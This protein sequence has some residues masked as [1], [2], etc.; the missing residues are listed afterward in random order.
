MTSPNDKAVFGLQSDFYEHLK[1]KLE[2]IERFYDTVVFSF[3]ERKRLIDGNL[4]PYVD[5]R[6]L[7]L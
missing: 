3:E 4:E 2:Y 7:E 5:T 6:N 1:S